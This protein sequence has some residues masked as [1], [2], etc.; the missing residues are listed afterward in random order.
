MIGAHAQGFNTGSVGVAVLGSYGT[1]P[2]SAAAK[3]SL[4]QLLAWKLD[5]AHVDP[6]S[7]LTWR[8]G[9]NPRFANGVPVFLRAISGHRDTGFTDCP[10][11]ALYAQ[12]PQIAKDV[13]AL[14]GPKIYAPLSPRSGEGQVR[15]T[16]QLTAA[17]PW[18]VTVTDSPGAQVAQGAAPAPR[19]LDLGRVAAPPDRY[20]WTIASA[21]ARSATGTLGAT[22]R[23]P[24][25]RRRRCRPGGAGRDRDVAYTLTSPATV[26]ATLVS[27]TGECSR[28]CSHDRSRQAPRRSRSP[29]AGPSDGR[30]TIGRRRRRGEDGDRDDPVHR[31]RHP[32]RVRGDR[33]VVG[34]HAY[35]CSDR[36]AFQVLRGSTVVAKPAVSRS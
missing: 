25:R 10:G 33:H 26:T 18:T 21:G 29:A 12:L 24:C 36:V 32:H 6:L 3:A 23:S 14:G 7:T 9:G 31:R 19:R 34:L 22:R 28:P 5:V 2:I 1:P 8:S 16:A 17:Q 27:P 13:A 4:E 30:Y 35:P 15:F 20:S 11:N